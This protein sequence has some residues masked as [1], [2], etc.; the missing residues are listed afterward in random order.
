MT[1]AARKQPRQNLTQRVT[2][3]LRERIVSGQLKPGDKLPTELELN[4]E[5]GVS[6]TVI[7]EAV[8]SLRADGLVQPKQGV[9][10]FVTAPP[11]RDAAREG[12]GFIQISPQKI[13]DVIEALELRTAV[14]VESAALAAL[15]CSPA[16]EAEICSR[17]DA[18]E[19]ALQHGELSESE[20]F[21]FHLSVA[22]ATN[23]P[24]F[25]EFLTYLG[26]R[27][28]PR[29]RL[30]EEAGLPRNQALEEQLN[31]EHRAILEAI[32]RHDPEAARTAMRQHLAG[33]TDRYRALARAAH[34][35][36]SLAGE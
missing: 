36:T 3:T 8:A 6:R 22:R 7:R 24:R 25:I 33:G 13:S 19:A 29:S 1:A 10:V 14:E 15:R 28:I 27:T 35:R 30:R 34:R 26:N 9:G 23:N 12:E 4:R 20:D 21:E 32:L 5:L 17:F 31:Q 16:Q 2:E 18:L 11:P